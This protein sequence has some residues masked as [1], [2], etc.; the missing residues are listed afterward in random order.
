MTNYEIY[1]YVFFGGAALSALMLVVSIILFVVLRIPNVI[2][3]LTGANARKAIENIRNQNEETGGKGYKPSAVNRERG[4]LTDKISKSGNLIRNPSTPIGGHE[5]AKISTMKLTPQ[6]RPADETTVLG[7]EETT[8]LQPQ[9]AYNETT[10][11][12]PQMGYNETTVL[13][14]QGG[15]NETT[16]LQPAMAPV[17]APVYEP[18]PAAAAYQS[19]PVAAFCVDLEITYIHTNEVIE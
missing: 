16:V 3:D 7:G 15:Y 19:A 17:A 1:R 18:A 2:G 12:Q 11:L 5:T 14:P 6:D 10:V 8:L 13:Q 4:K 9:G